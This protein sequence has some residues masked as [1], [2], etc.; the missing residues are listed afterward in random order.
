MHYSTLSCLF[1]TFWCDQVYLIL[2]CLIFYLSFSLYFIQ[3]NASAKSFDIIC[4]HNILKMVSMIIGI[5]LEQ[6]LSY[7][8]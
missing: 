5:F 8:K 4:L 2:F 1:T 3:D 7:A 6:I